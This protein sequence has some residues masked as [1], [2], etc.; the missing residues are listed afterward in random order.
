M[1]QLEL[2]TV[3]MRILGTTIKISTILALL[4]LT[5]AAYNVFVTL[6]F[7][8]VAIPTVTIVKGFRSQ[9]IIYNTEGAYGSRRDTY[10]LNFPIIK[11]HTATGNEYELLKLTPFNSYEEGQSIDVLYDP[12]NPEKSCQKSIGAIWGTCIFISFFGFV[13]L[14]YQLSIYIKKH[15]VQQRNP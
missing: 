7:L 10:I 14:F 9:S 5:V 6:L 15:R 3:S 1:I 4:F 13:I 11:F 2:L 12:K 8:R